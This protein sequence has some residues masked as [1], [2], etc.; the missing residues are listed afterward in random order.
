MYGIENYWGFVAAA[1]LLNLTPGSDTV[2]ILT[3]SIAEGRKAG[4]A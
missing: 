1:V 3:R 4:M 2:Y